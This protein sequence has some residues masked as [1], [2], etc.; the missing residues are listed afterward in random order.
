MR[1]ETFNGY[2]ARVIQHEYDHLEGK[3]FLDR[4]RSMNSLTTVANYI[5]FYHKS[6]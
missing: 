6:L 1:R 5:R 3:V 2:I 4:M